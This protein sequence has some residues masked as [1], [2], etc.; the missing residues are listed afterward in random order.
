V[1]TDFAGRVHPLVPAAAIFGLALA[2]R[3]AGAALVADDGY[4]FLKYWELAREL[5]Q[6]SFV[7]DRPFSY[8]PIY[9]YFVALA[10]LVLGESFGRLLVLQAVIGA[11]N[12]TLLYGV[13][14]R[15]VGSRWAVVP[16]GLA[17]FHHS[18]VVYDLALLSDALGL[19]FQLGLLLVLERPDEPPGT[20][21]AALAGVL[22]GLAALHRANNL[23]LLPLVLV[24]WSVSRPP[25]RRLL[26]DAALL[27]GATLLTTLPVVVQNLR[28]TGSPGITASNPGY[29][30]Y[31]SNNAASF[32]FRYSPPELYYRATDYY[33]RLAATRPETRFLGDAE[34]AAIVSGAI[35]GRPMS[36]DESSRYY[37]R[38]TL[39]HVRR[40]PRHYLG[41]ELHKLWLAVHGYESHD[42]AAVFTSA[43]TLSALAPLRL[44]WLAPLGILGLVASLPVWRR[45][46]GLWIV[47][48]NNLA[49]LVVFYVVVRFRLP[50]EAVLLLASGLALRT[51][52]GWVRG[53]RHA[54]ALIA[55]ALVLAALYVGCNVLPADLAE[56][57]R[58]RELEMGLEEASR[59]AS[60]GELD[61]AAVLLEELIRRDREELPRALAA[62]R[63]LAQIRARGSSAG[64]ATPMREPG[65]FE[66]GAVV[67]R[68]RVKWKRGTITFAEL[69][70]L[71]FLLRSR[72][73]PAT[74]GDVLRTALERRPPEPL[75]RYELATLEARAGRGE[76]ARS[77]LLTA[78]SDGLMFSTRGMHGALLLAGVLEAAGDS[79]GARAWTV[80]ASRLSALAPWYPE[81]TEPML[82]RLRATPGYVPPPRLDDLASGPWSAGR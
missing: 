81:D 31:S 72:G 62:H 78:M 4:P 20:R 49:L 44:G 38:F 79:S 12:C 73:E 48:V 6:A 55:A 59:L 80:Q 3:L 58:Y 15:L 28:L 54:R 51:L 33:Q 52:W 39:D 74:A 68:L 19:T 1:R 64:G 23:L 8:A 30:L 61:R 45:T 27:A 2:V 16:A 41:L 82:E 22:I 75:S 9:C 35:L 29:I 63:M 36:L 47:L 17:C 57:A 43:R 11:L 18:F 65:Y 32:G 76:A 66:P 37:L 69:Q 24:A 40:Y 67:E 10:Q 71:A 53:G 77:L 26:R 25:L 14:R 70:Y 60:A 34:I 56:R 7:A 42:V 5:R 46:L 13:A 21:R 50:I